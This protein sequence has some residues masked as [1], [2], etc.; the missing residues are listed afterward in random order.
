[1][2]VNQHWVYSRHSLSGGA[3]DRL[4]LTGVLETLLQSYKSLTAFSVLPQFPF[5]EWKSNTSHS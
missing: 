5:L 3:K 2:E 1:M 4:E